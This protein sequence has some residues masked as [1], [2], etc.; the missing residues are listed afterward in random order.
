MYYSKT[1]NDEKL[2][3]ILTKIC[4][5]K[6][7]EELNKKLDKIYFDDELFEKHFYHPKNKEFLKWK[8]QIKK[9]QEEQ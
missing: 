7:N 1:K 5:Q 3:E 9:S 2:N 8:E 4:L 6:I